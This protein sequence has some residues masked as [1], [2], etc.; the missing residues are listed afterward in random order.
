MIFSIN[1]KATEPPSRDQERNLSL[2]PPPCLNIALKY[3]VMNVSINSKAANLLE[4]QRGLRE[5]GLGS[6]FLDLT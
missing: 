2:D 3:I 6:A 5:L 4:T 1:H